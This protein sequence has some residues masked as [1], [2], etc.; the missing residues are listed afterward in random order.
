VAFT[1]FFRDQRVLDSIVQKLAPDV[2]HHGAIRVWD[3]GCSSGEEAYS[4]AMLVFENFRPIASGGLR[5]DATDIEEN[6]QFANTIATGIYSSELLKGSPYQELLTQIQPPAG[7]PGFV[8]FDA[9]L[10][11]C[12]FYQRQRSI[13]T[14]ANRR[15]FSVIVC[16]MSCCT[17]IRSTGECHKMFYNALSRG[18]NLALDEFKSSS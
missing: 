2:P 10:R 13:V 18:A 5:I 7:R 17:C 11:E 4:V 8:E 16:K 3:A 1:F 6:S 9:G 14:P 15:Q 12:I